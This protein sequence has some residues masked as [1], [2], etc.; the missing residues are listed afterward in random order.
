[1]NDVKTFKNIKN[2]IFKTVAKLDIKDAIGYDPEELNEVKKGTTVY[3]ISI[4]GN[5]KPCKIQ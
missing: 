3:E 5:A 2:A 1:M 4:D